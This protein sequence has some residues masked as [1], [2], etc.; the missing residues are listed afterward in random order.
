MGIV[1]MMSLQVKFRPPFSPS[2]ILHVDSKSPLFNVYMSTSFQC[3]SESQLLAIQ[4]PGAGG[5]FACL[6]CSLTQGSAHVTCEQ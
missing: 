2:F 6:F 5:D 4:G 1:M 3:R